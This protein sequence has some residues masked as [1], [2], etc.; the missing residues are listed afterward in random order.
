VTSKDSHRST[1][2]AEMKKK[3]FS[4]VEQVEAHL[5][6]AEAGRG[7]KERADRSCLGARGEVD[8]GGRLKQG[9][10]RLRSK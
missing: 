1:N 10:T 7:I 3:I 6:V 5:A 2:E 8:V 9:A 4:L